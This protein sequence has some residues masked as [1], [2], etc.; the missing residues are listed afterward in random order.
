M[1]FLSDV[2]LNLNSDDEQRFTTSQNKHSNP[3][4]RDGPKQK[5]TLAAK[6]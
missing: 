5:F 6:S 4:I 1:R 2:R 3:G